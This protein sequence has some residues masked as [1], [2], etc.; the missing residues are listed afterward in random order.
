[1]QAFHRP[2]AIHRVAAVASA[3]MKRL[4]LHRA[5]LKVQPSRIATAKPVI[6]SLVHG[7]A[8]LCSAISFI[9]FSMWKQKKPLRS[10]PE[11]AFQSQSH[12]RGKDT[13]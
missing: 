11:A 10:R 8:M 4:S 9:L 13:P 3:L 2:A 12:L 5:D 1:M 6:V 7:T